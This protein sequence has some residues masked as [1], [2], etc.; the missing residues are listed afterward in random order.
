MRKSLGCLKLQPDVAPR[1][2]TCIDRD[3]DRE[4]KLRLFAKDC[5]FLRYII[6]KQL[7]LIL[8]QPTNRSTV[9]IG[10]RSKDIDQAH[11]NFEIRLRI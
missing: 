6:F 2:R 10:H 11:I 5:N 8:R 4:R 1:A 9:L 7:E 3:N